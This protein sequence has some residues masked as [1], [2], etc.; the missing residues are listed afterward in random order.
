VLKAMIQ[1]NSQ[2][3]YNE[4]TKTLSIQHLLDSEWKAL[5]TLLK[6]KPFEIRLLDF[7][8]VKLAQNDDF[9]AM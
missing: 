5:C 3:H 9:E 1:N 7:E 6:H 2:W 4:T 8:T